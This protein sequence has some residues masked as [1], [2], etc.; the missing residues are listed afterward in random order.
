VVIFI[1]YL[2]KIAPL[3]N[4]AYEIINPRQQLDS[5]DI[6]TLGQIGDFLGGLLNP[7]PTLFSALLIYLTYKETQKQ[8]AQQKKENHEQKIRHSDEMSLEEDKINEDIFNRK[9][10]RQ[11]ERISIFISDRKLA[12]ELRNSLERTIEFCCTQV[13]NG[14]AG[15]TS[16]NKAIIQH[17]L[18][19]TFIDNIKK[20]LRLINTHKPTRFTCRDL[21][22]KDFIDELWPLESYIFI[23]LLFYGHSTEKQNMMNDQFLRTAIDLELFGDI[24]TMKKASLIVSGFNN[25]SNDAASNASGSTDSSKALKVLIRHYLELDDGK[26]FGPN[27]EDAS[28]TWR[29]AET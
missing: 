20:T 2:S 12:A 23:L 17:A 26:I 15:H 14:D 10:E 25:T 29:T 7:L 6:E 19:S 3:Q 24:V 28:K 18:L 13:A 16:V 9:L 1:L 8:L 27:K 21:L 22:L 11:Y 4:F 5:N